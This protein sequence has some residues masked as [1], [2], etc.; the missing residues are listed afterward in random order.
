MTI[1]PLFVNVIQERAQ[2]PTPYMVVSVVLPEMM[3]SNWIP[4]FLLDTN[5]CSNCAYLSDNGLHV[6][7]RKET[8]CCQN[9]LPMKNFPQVYKLFRIYLPPSHQK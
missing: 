9:A 6:P 4:I 8:C 1:S 2:T 5:C 7:L 3:P